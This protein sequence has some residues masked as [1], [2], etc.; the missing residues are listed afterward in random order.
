[1]FEWAAA[2]VCVL[3]L[4]WLVSVPAQ[5]LLGRNVQAA[6][7]EADAPNATP[8]GIP[9]GATIVPVMLLLDGREIRQG[10]LH[11]KLDQMLPANYADGPA[12][13]SQ[14]PFGERHTR[15]YLVNGV[16]FYVVCERSEPNGQMKVSGIYLP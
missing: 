10:D 8:R 16:K 4:I 2:A 1:M 5:R 12:E 14:T 6:N 9:A 13:R 7:A 15:R 3:A 11:T